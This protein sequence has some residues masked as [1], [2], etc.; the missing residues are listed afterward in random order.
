MTT[1]RSRPLDHGISRQ[2]FLRGAVGMLATG[3][4]FGTT[5]AAADPGELRCGPRDRDRDRAMAR[6]GR[7]GVGARRPAERAVSDVG[8]GDTA[9]PW[10]NQSTVLQWYGVA[11]LRFEHVAADDGA[12]EL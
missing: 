3:A 4:V 2:T 8:N 9:F 10:R 5:R 1:N 6:L 11:L 12:A 7:R